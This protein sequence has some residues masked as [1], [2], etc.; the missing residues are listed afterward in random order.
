MVES[1][2]LKFLKGIPACV[3]HCFNLCITTVEEAVVIPAPWTLPV[4]SDIWKT[5]LALFKNT[6]SGLFEGIFSLV[7]LK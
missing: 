4:L 6:K 2:S 3:R 1:S 5:F 7:S